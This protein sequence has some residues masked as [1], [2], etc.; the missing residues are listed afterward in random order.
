MKRPRIYSEQISI[1]PGIGKNTLNKL[2]QPYG[3]RQNFQSYSFNEM[4]TVFEKM[5]NGV[6][7]PEINDSY[8][9]ENVFEFKQPRQVLKIEEL[10]DEIDNNRFKTTYEQ[11]LQQEKGKLS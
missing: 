2:S 5:K 1:K 4:N 6:E 3:Y 9:L 8:L 11:R 10:I 7:P